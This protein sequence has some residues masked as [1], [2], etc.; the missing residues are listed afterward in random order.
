MTPP[1]EAVVIGRNE[2]ARLIACLAAL[3]GQVVRVIY[4]DSGSTDG[5]REA[6][7]R[8]GAELV[9][10][11]TAQPFTAAR[12]RNAGLAR[13]TA[14]FVQFVDG[15]C[16]LAPGWIDA[17]LAQM[18]SDPALAVVCGRRRELRPEA[19]VY[20]RLCDIEWNTPAGPARACGGDAL[21]RRAPLLAEGGFDATLI[22]GE[23]PD[24]C[25]RLR[26][27]GW[28]IYRLDAEMT[29]HDADMHRF[30][31]WWRRARRAGYA[32][33]E[34]AARHGSPPARHWVTER[35]RALIWGLVLPVVIFMGTLSWPPLALLALVYP[36]QVM[37]LG[38]RS[39]DWPWAFFNVLGKFAEAGGALRYYMARLRRRRGALIEYK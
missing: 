24:L 14:E 16:I 10:L 25:L 37:R 22:A 2:G 36:A 20:N 30:G 34:G 21:M 4:V 35:R 17:A 9:Q 12:A 3:E 29:Q 23:E 7:L 26:A 18:R 5:S 27:A 33:A 28:G 31:Q 6:A 8:E 1:V 11:D 19:S 32:F 15:D 38:L 39:G 13:C